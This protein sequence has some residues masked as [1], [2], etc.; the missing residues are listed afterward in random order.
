MH[1]HLRHVKDLEQNLNYWLLKSKIT[2]NY[3]FLVF[4]IQIYHSIQAD[5][6]N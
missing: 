1:K 2:F 3:I 5:N 4:V 6:T